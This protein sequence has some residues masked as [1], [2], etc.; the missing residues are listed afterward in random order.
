VRITGFTYEYLGTPPTGDGS[1]GGAEGAGP[2]AF[3]EGALTDGDFNT[4]GAVQQE[5]W[6]SSARW[7][8]GVENN[9][10]I[11]FD[12]QQEYPLD[13][14][15]LVSHAPHTWSGISKVRVRFK[16]ENGDWTGFVEV[17]WYGSPMPVTIGW[18]ELD[19]PCEGMTARYVELQLAR[20]DA[21]WHY[22]SLTEVEF[23]RLSIPDP[24]LSA[25]SADKDS[26]VAD[27]KQNIKVTVVVKDAVGPVTDTE[28]ELRKVPDS[29]DLPFEPMTART[30]SQGEAVFYIKSK[31]AGEARLAAYCGTV[32]LAEIE[33][34]FT[35]VDV[36][37]PDDA[38]FLALTYLTNNPIHPLASG[39]RANTII[40][41]Y[42]VDPAVVTVRVFDRQGRVVG[43]L[44]ERRHFD[45]GYNQIEW[46]GYLNGAPL[47]RGIYMIELKAEGQERNA[48]YR[49]VI[50]IW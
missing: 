11:L 43:Y 48:T 24:E 3:G 17:P 4:P 25:A 37:P 12:L 31:E 29:G 7:T 15:H 6:G 34:S 44:C 18:Y 47:Q 36:L 38:E 32:L 5:R 33:I 20:Q 50:G 10:P 41:F 23:F 28:V 21:T 46:N 13:K 45:G 22:M 8:R 39:E 49:E 27:G 9:Q 30:N 42:L 19:I 2:H 35:A 14:I 16:G 26:Q 40:N 1:H